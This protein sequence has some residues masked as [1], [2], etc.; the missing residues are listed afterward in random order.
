MSGQSEE[1]SVS[2]R[3]EG[4]SSFNP[5]ERSRKRTEKY[6]VFAVTEGNECP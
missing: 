2:R 3:R 5:D 1:E 6:L 4:S